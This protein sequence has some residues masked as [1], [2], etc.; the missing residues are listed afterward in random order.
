MIDQQIIYAV[1]TK[2]FACTALTTVVGNNIA[3]ARGPVDNTWPQ[4]HF[5]K[6]STGEGYQVD[7]NQVTIQMSVWADDKWTALSIKEIIYNEFKRYIGKIATSLGVVD[8]TWTEMI[9]SGALPEADSTLFGEY[10][11]F[12]FRYRGANL[13]GL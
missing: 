6:V 4:V 1:Q 10:L 11:R 12:K 7:F 13:G 8:I 2:L 5:F 9:D 3:F